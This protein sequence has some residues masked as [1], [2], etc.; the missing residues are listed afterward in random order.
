MRRSQIE[1]M[2]EV[3]NVGDPWAAAASF[4][5]KDFLVRHLF[6]SLWEWIL[7]QKHSATNRQI[8]HH[9]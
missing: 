7:I 8:S 5:W 9:N 2:P 1:H 4:E 6:V 3:K